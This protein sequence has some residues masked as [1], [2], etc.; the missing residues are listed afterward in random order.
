M[1]RRGRLKRA[2]QE[3]LVLQARHY[4]EKPE[5]PLSDSV[6]AGLYLFDA[7]LLF[8]SIRDA[9]EAKVARSAYVC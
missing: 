9:M 2:E 7:V 1:L 6:N 3:A 8:S 4:V 5:E